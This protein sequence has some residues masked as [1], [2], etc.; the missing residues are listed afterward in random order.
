MKGKSS[1]VWLIS[2]L[3]YDKHDEEV[4]TRDCATLEADNVLGCVTNEKNEITCYCQEEDCNV[5]LEAA[6]LTTTAPTTTT[7]TAKPTT[8]KP[9]TK[10]PTTTKK[11]T[12]TAKPTEK[13]TTTTKVTTVAPTTAEKETTAPLLIQKLQI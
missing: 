10:A 11:P 1:M 3:E 2:N 8:A 7:T 5:D 9:T 12:T 13:P 6:G 4:W